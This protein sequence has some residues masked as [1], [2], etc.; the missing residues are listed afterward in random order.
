ML[1]VTGKFTQGTKLE[2]VQNGGIYGFG[3]AI[4]IQFRAVYRIG[5]RASAMVCANNRAVQ[6]PV[7]GRACKMWSAPNRVVRFECYCMVGLWSIG[8]MHSG[9]GGR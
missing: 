8:V 9:A 4:L 1:T 5:Q 7:S 2:S 6:R 3:S